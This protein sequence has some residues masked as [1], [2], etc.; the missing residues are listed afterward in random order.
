MDQ[1]HQQHLVA[2]TFYE[3]LIIEFENCLAQFQ[4]FSDSFIL[5]R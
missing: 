3:R 2:V 4:T 5:V 1:Q